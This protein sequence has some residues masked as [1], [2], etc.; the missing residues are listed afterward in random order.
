MSSLLSPYEIFF[1]NITSVTKIS[2]CTNFEIDTYNLEPKINIECCVIYVILNLCMFL[3]QMF[4]D[5][6]DY[7]TQLD[8]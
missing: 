1:T 4:T 3:W 8:E 5:Y 6:C 2:F 7:L